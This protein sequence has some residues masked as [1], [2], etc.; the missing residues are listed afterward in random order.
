VVDQRT[1]LQIVIRAQMSER[2]DFNKNFLTSSLESKQ[3][4][5][6]KLDKNPFSRIIILEIFKA[7]FFSRDNVEHLMHTFLAREAEIGGLLLKYFELKKEYHLEV[8]QKLNTLKKP[9]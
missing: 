4:G 1:V 6:A 2:T 8:K 5:R 7:T 9:I 3:L